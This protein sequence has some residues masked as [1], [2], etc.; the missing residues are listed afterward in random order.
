MAYK[1]VLVLAL[2]AMAEAGFV[3]TQTGYNPYDNPY[4]PTPSPAQLQQQADLIRAQQRK[5]NLLLQNQQ[6]QQYNPYNKYDPRNNQNGYLPPAYAYSYSQPQY[7][8]RYPASAYAH[9]YASPTNAQSIYQ[10]QNNP[11]I[12]TTT[13]SP[14]RQQQSYYNPAAAAQLAQLYRNPHAY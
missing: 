11:Q 6:N 14:Y 7:T 8:H 12:Y 13:P 1:L 3:S 5:I 4:A 9:R 2:F 10:T